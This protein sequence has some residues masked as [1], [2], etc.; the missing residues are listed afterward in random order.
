MNLGRCSSG[1]R[2]IDRIILLEND[3]ILNDQITK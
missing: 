3:Q 2:V 1:Y